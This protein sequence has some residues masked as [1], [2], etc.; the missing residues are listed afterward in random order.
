M[1]I[2]VL[3]APLES[4]KQA[5]GEISNVDPQIKQ[6]DVL[7]QLCAI[8]TDTSVT[9]EKKMDIFLDLGITYFNLEFGAISEIKGDFYRVIYARPSGKTEVESQFFYK[10]TYCS[11][12]FGH[13][14][15]FS[16]IDAKNSEISEHPCYKNQKLNS[17]IGTTIFVNQKPFGTVSFAKFESRTSAFSNFEKSFL[18]LIAQFISS[19]LTQENNLSKL[20]ESNNF[21]QLVQDVIPD[22]IFVKDDKFRIVRANPAFINV[23]PE[24]SR[25]KIIGFTTLESYDDSEAEEFLKFDKKALKEGFSQTEETILFPDG[26]KRTLE[27]KKIRFYDNKDKKYLLGIGRDITE[28]KKHED[29]IAESKERYE[30]AIK[31]ASVGL[32]DWNVTTNE[33]FWSDR[34]KE[35]V[36]ISDKEFRPCYE[37]FSERLHPHDKEEIETALFSHIENKTPYKVEYRLKRNDGTYVWIHAR[38]QAIWDAEGKATRMAGSVDDISDKKAALDEILRSNKELERFAYVASHDLQEPLRMV[39]NFTS[40]LERNYRDILDERGLEYIKYAKEGAIR[41]QKLVKDLLEYASIGDQ[42]ENYEIVDLNDIP[43]IVESA[44]S[45]TIEQSNALV[46]WQDNLPRIR[47]NPVRILSVF[48]NVIGNSIKYRK[49]NESPK[50]SITFEPMHD[51]WVFIIS[52]NGIGMKQEYCSKIFEPFKRLHRND[53][54]PGTGMGLSICRKTI[55]ELGGKIWAESELS[56]GTQVFFTL[57]KNNK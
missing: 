52:D 12:V 8:A 54:Y 33:L 37:E 2:I 16:V 50:I 6:E 38:G 22:L 56:L 15:V 13:A 14:H 35:I 1:F 11:H 4:K 25:D 51:K 26:K 41:M 55:E 31:G 46:E 57:P 43:S 48:Q 5:Q 7:N 47:V 21:L 39:S 36:G 20:E 17:Y 23:Y 10:D 27:T 34:F 53:Q 30:L 49:E 44:L 19:E 40:L 42:G 18:Q 24:S 45:A 28:R 32:W 9:L 29:I 3:G